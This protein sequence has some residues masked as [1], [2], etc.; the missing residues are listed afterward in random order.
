ME[1]HNNTEAEPEPEQEIDSENEIMEPII[2][3]LPISISQLMRGM[4]LGTGIGPEFINNNI[5]HSN[6]LEERIQHQSFHERNKYKKVCDND[7]IN[8]LSVQKTTPEMVEQNTTCG[9]CLE[10]LKEGEDIIELPCQDKHYFHIKHEGCPGIYPWLKE[11][12]TC[13]MCRHEFPS[14]EKEIEESDPTLSESTSLTPIRR[15]RPINL[16][17]II[18]SAIEEQEDRMLQQAIY[19]SMNPVS[20]SE[21]N[22]ESEDEML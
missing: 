19:Q 16:M 6:N 14:V 3:P 2:L 5:N 18:N 22:S 11:N 15:L 13:P 10:E 12:H 9:V 8:S 20:N 7:F 21:T 1:D 4:V 17:N